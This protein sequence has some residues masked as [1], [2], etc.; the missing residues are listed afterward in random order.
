MNPGYPGYPPR[1]GDDP[2]QRSGRGRRRAPEVPQQRPALESGYGGGAAGYG[3]QPGYGGRGQYPDRPRQAEAGGYD[4]GYPRPDQT[5]GFPRPDVTGGFPRPDTAGGYARP[6]ARPDIRPDQAGYPRADQTGGF[7]RPDTTGGFPRA[8]AGATGQFRRPDPGDHRAT[9]EFRRPDQTGQFSRPDAGYPAAGGYPAAP[10]YPTSGGNAGYP[11]SGGYPTSGGNGGY[12]TSGYPASGGGA[13]YPAAGGSAGY[14]RPDQTGGFPR[15]DQTG[16]FPRPGA[17][18]TGQFRRPDAGS[19]GEF[20]RPDQTG[21]FT[22]PDAGYPRPDQTGEFRRPGGRSPDGLPTAPVYQDPADYQGRSGYGTPPVSPAPAGGRGGRRRADTRTGW[23]RDTTGQQI[24]VSPAPAGESAPAWAPTGAGAPAWAGSARPTGSASVTDTNGGQRWTGSGTATVPAARNDGRTATRTEARPDSRTDSRTEG[25]PVPATEP[26]PSQAARNTAR[27]VILTLW[28]AGLSFPALLWW[29]HTTALD[30]TGAVLIAAGR[31]TGLVAGYTLLTQIVL[32]ARLP[33]LQRAAG[34]ERML[35]WHRDIGALLVVATI[36]HALLL[37]EGYAIFSGDGPI[38]EGLRLFNDQADMVGAFSAAAILTGLALLSIRQLRKMMP[39]EAW[40]WIHRSAYVV[41]YL[42]YAHQFSA[43]SDIG[44]GTGKIYWIG[45]HVLVIGAVVWGRIGVPLLINMYH[46]VRVAE[47]VDEGGDTVSIYLS[48][49][50]LDQLG[51]RSGQYLR[52]RFLQAGFISQAHPF[53]LSAPPNSHWLRITAKSV[54]RFTSKLPELQPETRVWVSAPEG[55]H[56]PASRTMTKAVLI[57][58]GSGI[59]PARALLPELPGDT[60]VVYRASTPE[61]LVLR[62]ELEEITRARGGKV[63]VVT[64]RRDESGPKKLLTSWGL[65]DLVPDITMRD[66]YLCG[67]P[68]FAKAI[69]TALR[70][71]N[72]PKRQIHVS[73]FEL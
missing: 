51:A 68:E 65:A 66:I 43:G 8:G 44:Q 25:R 36:A 62:A 47:V 13:G 69:V 58:A 19:T 20:R 23:G 1:A 22:R 50:R 28:F 10:G 24:P 60:V 30:G 15:P 46:R 34:A 71:L 63:H 11:A 57:S 67:P 45:L 17:G 73:A 12:P 9:G 18:S 39:Y 56:T 59:A 52:W 27:R 61:Q 55:E 7:P 42:G 4:R 38:K 70:P 48:G 41:L 5:G 32:M 26:P 3:Q 49:N 53:S 37:I 40:I 72:V 6:D 21:Q 33:G 54:G 14:P 35:K 64:G 29:Q 31:L 16:G 2:G